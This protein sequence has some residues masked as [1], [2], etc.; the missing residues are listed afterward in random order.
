MVHDGVS[1][2]ERRALR[3]KQATVVRNQKEAPAEADTRLPRSTLMATP[4]E[5]V[6]S[7]LVGI[8][9]AV[10]ATRKQPMPATGLTVPKAN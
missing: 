5:A 4:T 6:V 10:L 3:A 1:L 8:F 2:L 7:E 9:D